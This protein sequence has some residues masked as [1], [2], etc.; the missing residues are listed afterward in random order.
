V[1]D[2]YQTCPMCGRR[3]RVPNR[4]RIPPHHVTPLRSSA[5]CSVAGLTPKQART[6]RERLAEAVRSTIP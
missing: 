1:A 4:R 2:E 5:A 6:A 3:V